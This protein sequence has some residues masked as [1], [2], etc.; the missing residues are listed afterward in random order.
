MEPHS[1]PL[2]QVDDAEFSRLTT[3]FIENDLSA[4]D[5]GRLRAILMENDA[6]RTEFADFT[7]VRCVAKHLFKSGGPEVKAPVTSAGHRALRLTPLLLV[8]ALA[9]MVAFGLFLAQWFYTKPAPT[10]AGQTDGLVMRQVGAQWATAPRRHRVVAG[11]VYRLNAGFAQIRLQSGV[12]LLINGPARFKLSAH[13]EMFLDAGRVV[14][15]AH[16]GRFTIK[17]P[18]AVI[19]DLGTWFAVWQRQ[20]ANTVVGVYEGRVLV[21]SAAP[22]AMARAHLLT[23]GQASEVSTAGVRPVAASAWTQYF[24]QSIDPKS[25]TLSVADLLCGGNGLTNHAGCGIDVATGVVGHLPQIARYQSDGLFHRINSIPALD[26]SFVPQGNLP[27]KIDSAGNRCTFASGSNQGYFLLWLGGAFPKP[28]WPNAQ[29]MSPVLASVNYSAVGH[30]IMYLHPNKGITINLDAVR[31]MYPADRL[32][33]FQAMLGDTYTPRSQHIPK[34]SEANFWILV[35]GKRRF[36]KHGL[37]PAASAV[38]LSLPLRPSDHFLTIAD[39]AAT[40][41]ISRDWIILGDPT[42]Q[43]APR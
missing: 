6:R 2:T 34:A 18:S 20:R 21:A 40:R 16:G 13:R 31:R 9:A 27:I 1:T 37:T 14:A 26:G 23:T 7:I 43:L 3:L 28:S 36:V 39:T 38:P 35:N 5:I 32:T 30:S 33:S 8:W 17:T 24:A 22:G 19:K 29:A 10:T 15:K 41:H 42:L 12:Q 11:V 25:Q 4:A